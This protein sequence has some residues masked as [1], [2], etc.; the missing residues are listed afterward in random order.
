M[1]YHPYLGK[2][3]L[4]RIGKLCVLLDGGSFFGVPAILRPDSYLQMFELTTRTL[5]QTYT[6]MNI[7]PVA[8]SSHR[9]R[10]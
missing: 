9:V 5:N 1:G 4:G 10:G 6:L 3:E 7:H 8:S 2:S